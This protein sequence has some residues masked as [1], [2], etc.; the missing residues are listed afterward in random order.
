LTNNSLNVELVG[1]SGVALGLSIYVFCREHASA[2]SRSARRTT[3]FKSA[4]AFSIISSAVSCATLL[5][6]SILF[7]L[8]AHNEKAVP[9]MDCLGMVCSLVGVLLGFFGTG[10]RGPL[11]VG[12]SGISFTV[13]LTCFAFY[14][15]RFM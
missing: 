4:I 11:V 1:M 3:L 12:S 14:M 5:A 2:G 6:Q 8:Q 15:I 9:T 10:V 13:W 7:T